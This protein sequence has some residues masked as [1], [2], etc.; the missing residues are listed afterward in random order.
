VE[1]Y[2]RSTPIPSHPRFYA[3]QTRQDYEVNSE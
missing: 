2:L 1:E 3:E